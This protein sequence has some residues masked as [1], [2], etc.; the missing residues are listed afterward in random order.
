MI[1]IQVATDITT[2]T[3]AEEFTLKYSG[4]DHIEGIFQTEFESDAGTGDV[5]LQG[6]LHSDAPWQTLVTHTASNSAVVAH[7]SRR[8]V[9]ARPSP[10]GDDP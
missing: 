3:D 9:L 1:V 6:R 10:S 8:S 5:N 7:C 4:G 2:D